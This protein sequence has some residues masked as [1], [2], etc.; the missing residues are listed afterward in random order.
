MPPAPTRNVRTPIAPDP[1]QV[2]LSV[3]RIHS[4]YVLLVVILGIF[5][6]RS[7]YVQVIRYS[8]YHK[9]ATT[10]QFKQYEISPRRG[11]I[12][13]YDGTTLVP[14]VLN[15]KLY[16]V[17]ADPT[18][19]KNPQEVAGT[20]AAT[21][22]GNASDFVKDLSAKNT[23]Y[24]V[25]AKKVPAAKKEK[26]LNHKYPGIGAQ[27]QD[28]RTYPQ[29]SLASQLL[30]FVNNDG[31]GVYGLEQALNKELTGVPGQVK[32]VTD[33]RGVPLVA[34]GNNVETHPVPG[35]DVVLSVD[36]G[37]QHQV[38]QIL[39]DHVRS[40]NAPSGSV[41][42]M[43][44]NTGAIKAMANYPTYDPA[45]YGNVKDSNDFNNA[46]VSHPIEVGSV[47]KT[48][49]TAA[50]LD[51]GV[52]QKNTTYYDPSSWIVDD[53]KITNIEEDGGAGTKSIAELL[54]LSLNTGA[55]WELM[56]M[57]GGKLDR[58]GRE[59][60]YDYMTKHF[61]FG[62][63]TGVEQGSPEYENPGYVPP[64]E[65]NG[66]GISL[67]YANT[68]FGQAMTATPVQM[69]A[70]LGAVLNG[71][72]YYQPTLIS[73]TVTPDGKVQNH[74]PK[75]IKK[76]IVKPQVGTDLQG[77]ME[78]VVQNHFIKPPFDQS[79]Y[80]VGGKTGT[81]QVAKPEGGY[82]D[83]VFNGTYLGFVGGDRPQYV[84]AVFMN[85]PKVAG[86]AGTGAAQPVFVDVAHMLI[87]NAYVNPK[88]K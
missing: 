9:A 41:V 62:K 82:Y 3:R 7:F 75:I 10:E 68:S 51:R 35:D 60:W 40:V 65:N 79:K 61:M 19:I 58:Q 1:A 18:F 80:S 84:I 12:K 33:A 39:K 77:L 29:G 70:A 88:S 47:M 6:L 56:Q 13:A 57:G 52:I 44:P 17:Y 83:D 49:T 26:L 28:Y 37:I 23:R 11:T 64:P 74:E 63:Q 2:Q 78:Y 66:A 22:G 30:G 71:G 69:A 32:A 46:A 73:Q 36:I 67:T 85:R 45:N 21:I 42:V 27:E 72:T 4:W 54:N 8:H 15:Q 48:L 43:D 86:Y 34:T 31:E 50:A 87:N 55:V 53:F 25:L 16:T 5:M 20:V 76:D 38:E 81:A 24:V 59:V 14:I